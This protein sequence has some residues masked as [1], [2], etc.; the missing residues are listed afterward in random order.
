[1][2]GLFARKEKTEKREELTYRKKNQDEKPHK[3]EEMDKVIL[4]PGF[5]GLGSRPL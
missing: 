1:M 3:L 5:G 2:S 4:G